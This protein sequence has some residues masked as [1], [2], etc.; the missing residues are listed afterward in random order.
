MSRYDELCQS[1]EVALKNYYDH[2][3]RIED[4]LRRLFLP[5]LLRFLECPEDKLWTFDFY[6]EWDNLPLSKAMKADDECYWTVGLGI[7]ME[8][9]NAFMDLGY[10]LRCRGI[11]GRFTVQ[12]AERTFV[13]DNNTDLE[14]C[15]EHIFWHIKHKNEEGLHE[16]IRGGPTRKIGFSTQPIGGSR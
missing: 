15:F 8:K 9:A 1:C 14:R 10:L 12:I 2:K 11:D 6:S 3:D 7:Q 5:G 4:F 13:L 16:A